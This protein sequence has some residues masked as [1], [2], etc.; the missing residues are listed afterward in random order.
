VTYTPG[1]RIEWDHEKNLE[2]GR[3]HGLSFEEA[4]ELFESGTDY[5]EIFDEYHSVTED[6]FIC[7]GPIRAGLVLV[8][9]TEPAEHV[10]R[11]VSATR[12]ERTLYKDYMEG[13]Q[14]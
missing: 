2:N 11:I 5:F 14:G 6:R 9:K 8:V 10:V 13:N 7:I 4:R 3:K 1:E 12:H